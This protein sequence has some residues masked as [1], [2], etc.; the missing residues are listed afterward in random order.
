MFYIDK[1]YEVLHGLMKVKN[2][3]FG[4]WAQNQYPKL[5]L[6]SLNHEFNPQ[7]PKSPNLI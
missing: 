4:L 5:N 1:V 2:G 7:I 3:H 6:K